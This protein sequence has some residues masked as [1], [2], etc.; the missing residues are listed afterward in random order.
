ML[1]LTT[2]PICNNV[3]QS[4]HGISQLQTHLKFSTQCV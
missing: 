1:Q 4:T 3:C 2:V